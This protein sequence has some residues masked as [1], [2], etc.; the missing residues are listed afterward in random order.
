MEEERKEKINRRENWITEVR[1]V[2]STLLTVG[3][4]PRN[5]CLP[6]TSLTVYLVRGNIMGVV[7]QSGHG[8]KFSR[9]QSFTSPPPPLS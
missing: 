8:H 3:S 9:M 6:L 5:F 1:T 7:H 4:A 2:I